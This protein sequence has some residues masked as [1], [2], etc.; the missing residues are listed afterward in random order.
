[1][2]KIIITFNYILLFKNVFSNK[3]AEGVKLGHILGKTRVKTKTTLHRHIL[4]I[5]RPN[6]EFPNRTP[7][8]TTQHLTAPYT[9]S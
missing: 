1:M 6:P 8:N 3:I 7:H 4:T 9:S 2:Q 5:H